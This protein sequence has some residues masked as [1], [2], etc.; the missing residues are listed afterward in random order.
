MVFPPQQPIIPVNPLWTVNQTRPPWFPPPSFALY[1]S[2]P[3][4]YAPAHGAM[5]P[6]IIMPMIFVINAAPAPSPPPSVVV[7][8][9]NNCNFYGAPPSSEKE[10]SASNEKEESD[11]I[12]LDS[13]KRGNDAIDHTFGI[14]GCR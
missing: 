7:N 1:P 5:Q 9:Y 13:K 4:Q 3:M 2:F 6:P 10:E 14:Q 8:N 11:K 12:K